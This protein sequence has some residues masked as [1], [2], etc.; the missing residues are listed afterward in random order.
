MAASNE[1]ETRRPTRRVTTV[2]VAGTDV[3]LIDVINDLAFDGSG[4]LAE[5]T[6][7]KTS[8]PAVLKRRASPTGAIQGQE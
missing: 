4:P 8:R 6:E 1:S 2:P 7:P 3:L 5:E